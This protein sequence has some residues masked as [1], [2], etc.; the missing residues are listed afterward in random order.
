MYQ[1]EDD[2]EELAS[3]CFTASDYASDV[4]EVWPE[5]WS[6]FVLFSDLQTQW[7]VGGMGGVIGLDY[8]V[9]FHKLDRMS[10]AG[11]DYA[12]LEDHIHAM[13]RQALTTMNEK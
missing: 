11:D 10:L 8:N 13:E 9:M 2:P 3:F 1:R 5:N 7:R 6:A 12:Q 4:Y